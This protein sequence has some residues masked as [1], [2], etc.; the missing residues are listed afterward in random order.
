MYKDLKSVA[1]SAGLSLTCESLGIFWSIL[2]LECATILSLGGTLLGYYG[3]REMITLNHIR[4]DIL[5][6]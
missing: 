1:R 5:R 3:G 4:S 2:D 6:I